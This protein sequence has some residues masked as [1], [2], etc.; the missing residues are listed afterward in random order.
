MMLQNRMIS[1]KNNSLKQ[2]RSSSY[3][4]QKQWK[5]KAPLEFDMQH[6]L[7]PPPSPSALFVCTLK[8]RG[9]IC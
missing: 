8:F 1:S 9:L 5:E 6:L 4:Q 3:A 2:T 7:G